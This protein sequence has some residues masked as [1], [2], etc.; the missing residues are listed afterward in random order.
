MTRLSRESFSDA[1]GERT[2]VPLS[3]GHEIELVFDG[4]V[5]DALE[6]EIARARETIHLTMYIWRE[7]EA[8]DRVVRALVGRAR[9]GVRVRVLVDPIGTRVEF[10]RVREEL[11]AGGCEVRRF[12]RRG[13]VEATEIPARTHRKLL[14]VDGESAITGGFCIWD[15]GLGDG[16]RPDEWRDT[17]V[18]FRGPAVI[19][20]QQAFVE[21]WIA[22][23]GQIGDDDA[24]AFARGT[25]DVCAAFV[26]SS[27]G[28]V[29]TEAEALTE[30]VI[31]TAR[32][33]LWIA[34]AYFVPDDDLVARLAGAD[35]QGVDVRILVPGPIH[36]LPAV[37]LAQRAAYG[38]LLGAGVRIFEYQP[39]MMHAKAMLA[40]DWLGVVGSINLEPMSQRVIAEGSLVFDAPSLVRQLAATFETDLSRSREVVRERSGLAWVAGRFVRGAMTEFADW[41]RAR[42]MRRVLYAHRRD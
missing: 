16:L 40:D 19:A 30:L 35:R 24:L 12:L 38:P 13:E 7:G 6:E 14:I 21:Q 33:R 39:S 23:G 2:G 5:F 17:N 10:G 9:A 28:H 4:R 32:E 29:P 15:K 34:S 31:R 27:G 18:R 25:G 36:D 3:G 20:A 41:V 26:A 1:L 42:R 11:V 37:R 8:S 22:A